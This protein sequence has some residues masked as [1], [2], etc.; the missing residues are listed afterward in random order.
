[1][2]VVSALA[3]QLTPAYSS[4]PRDDEERLAITERDGLHV[5]SRPVRTGTFSIRNRRGVALTLLNQEEDAPIP[6]FGK[7]AR[8]CGMVNV[9]GG[10]DVETVE[11]QVSV[12]INSHLGRIMIYNDI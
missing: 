2:C 5:T 9:A 3:S 12:L 4:S 11:V 6:C 8:I 1:M 7:N 10:G